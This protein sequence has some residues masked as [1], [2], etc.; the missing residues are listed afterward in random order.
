MSGCCPGTSCWNGKEC[1]PEMSLINENLVVSTEG[2]FVLAGRENT[3]ICLK[4][5]WE[6]ISDK[7]K[8]DPLGITGGVCPSD[9]CYISTSNGFVLE[10]Q[11]YDY[12]GVDDEVDQCFN[13]P[14]TLSG[15][16][17]D[18]TNSETRGCF[19]T[20]GLNSEP[21]S[22]ENVGIINTNAIENGEEYYLKIA[23]MRLKKGDY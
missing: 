10:N 13:S 18:T 15:N 16:F 9:T 8:L 23:N 14:N 3:Y 4:N 17:D 20:T 1:V 5:N 21:Q 2:L 12:D 7:L 11:D 19:M 22:G 6:L